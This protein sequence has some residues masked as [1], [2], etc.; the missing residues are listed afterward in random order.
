LLVSRKPFNVF[1]TED[2]PVAKSALLLRI[3]VV[4]TLY[5]LNV[6]AFYIYVNRKRL[7]LWL[8]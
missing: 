8:S 5:E 7:A 4:E 2:V 3:V 6:L 1:V